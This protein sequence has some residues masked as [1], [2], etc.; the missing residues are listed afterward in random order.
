MLSAK[1]L[2][3][4]FINF[5]VSKG[6]TAIKSAPLVPENDPTVLF[7][8]AG[9]H[10]LVPFLLGEKHPGGNKLTNV[11]KCLRTD[12]IEEVGDDTHGTFFEMLGYWS[13]GDY[14]KTQSIQNTYDFYTQ[15]LKIPH[16]KIAV[17]VFAGDGDAPFDEESYQAWHDTIGIDKEKI[18][19]YS[20]KE[21]WWGPAGVTGPCGP[22]TEMFID[23]GTKSCGPDCGPACDC[24]KFVE[25]GNNVF[26]EYFKNK[27][28]SFTRLEQRNVDVGLGFERLLM[29]VQGYNN[30]FQTELFSPIIEQIRLLSA[31]YDEKGARIIADHLRAAIFI[32][33]DG[34][35]PSNVDQGYILRRLI[36]RAIRYANLLQI[37][38]KNYLATLSQVII[39]TLGDIYPEITNSGEIIEIL[40]TE[41]R[42]FD[43]CLECGEKEFSKLINVLRSHNQTTISG[44]SAFKLYESYGLPIEM[45]EEMAQEENFSLDKKEFDEA[46]Q[47]HQLLSRKGAQKKF[48]GG[49]A[50]H[51]DLVVRYHTAAHLLHTALR[52]ILG[53]H[54]GQAGSNITA[55]R[56]RFD[57][58]HTDKLTDD[59]KL[60]V[61]NMVNEQIAKSLPVIMQEMQLSDAKAS[62]ALG[63]FE[64]KYGEIVK[65]YTIGHNDKDYFSR[66]ICGGPHV[67][68]TSEL[69][70]FK[71]VS[72]KS[73]S[74]GIRRIK[75]VL[76]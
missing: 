48:A 17:T 58:R 61:E 11:Q 32:I 3:Q 34:V 1:Q 60:Q 51:S 29:F 44:R 47:K 7:T 75:A 70:H 14:W 41:Q 39:G 57:F 18:Y 2:R 56:L 69:G 59:E 15:V 28:G 66:E 38:D 54:V 31:K 74:A 46:Y 63:F 8:T 16:E 22:C 50:D 45:I 65:V 49:L 21:N 67:K 72:E 30:I 35:A 23:T 26:M 43:K 53:D 36:R 55:E 12:D 52:N 68:N 33:A 71:I 5:F 27:E 62:G 4:K 40:E 37:T 76:E 20:K 25:I 6:H 24:G 64:S 9:M 73:A 42:K 19:K 10:P 13:L